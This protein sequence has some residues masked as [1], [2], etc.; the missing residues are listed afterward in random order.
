VWLSLLDGSILRTGLENRCP[1]CEVKL[2]SLK[3]V[4][5]GAKQRHGY[6]DQ[7]LDRRDRFRCAC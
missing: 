4:G 5:Q 1:L 3:P 6:G 2:D 7:C